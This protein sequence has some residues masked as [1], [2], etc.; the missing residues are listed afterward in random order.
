MEKYAVISDIHSN[1]P[2]LSAVLHEIQ[3]EG[4]TQ[5]YNLGDS[6]GYH[7]MPNETIFLLQE[8]RVR[9]LLGNHDH[10]ILTKQFSPQTTPDIFSWTWHTLTRKNHSW[11]AMLPQSIRFIW[12]GATFFLCHGSP[13]SMEEYCHAGTPYT[14][15]MAELIDADY[16]LCGHTHIP[17]SER[18]GATAVI[19]PGSVGKPK[20]GSPHA[21]WVLLT[22]D[23]HQ[24]IPT[25]RQT[26]YPISVITKSLNDHGFSRY[27]KHL[28]TG[29]S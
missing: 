9:S 29:C 26:P 3:Q 17:Y 18:Y 1:S 25:F 5:I 10:A 27:I 23:S 11:L 16:L 14:R 6:L 22:A 21:S 12:H 20:H 8:H 13:E 24:I 15:T 2:A 7:T 28:E 4:V 19:N